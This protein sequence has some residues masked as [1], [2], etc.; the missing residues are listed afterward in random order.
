MRASAETCSGWTA[1][2]AG[3]VPDAGKSARIFRRGSR[4]TEK[5]PGPG[6]KT[7]KNSCGPAGPQNFANSNRGRSLWNETDHKRSVRRAGKTPGRPGQDSG[8]AAG[9]TAPQ[10]VRKNPP[11]PLA[12]RLGALS[13][14][15]YGFLAACALAPSLC[16]DLPA[17]WHL[18]L[19][20]ALGG[21]YGFGAL[22]H[23]ANGVDARI[24]RLLAAEWRDA[25]LSGMMPRD[26]RHVG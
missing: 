4:G 26:R 20:A 18:Y 19:F 3:P 24:Y 1:P 10:S 6:R 17:P 13:C 2:T 8:A 9:S 11:C 16:G 7:N 23:R 25:A 21:A 5:Q 14:G 15:L 22:L 12:L